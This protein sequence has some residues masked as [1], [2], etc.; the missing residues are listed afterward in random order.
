MKSLSFRHYISVA[1]ACAVAKCF[2]C[3][4]SS[5]AWPWSATWSAAPSISWPT[6]GSGRR[7]VHACLTTGMRDVRLHWVARFVDT[8][9]QCLLR[10][11]TQNCFTFPSISVVSGADMRLHDWRGKQH[12]DPKVLEW[13]LGAVPDKSWATAWRR[14]HGWRAVRLYLITCIAFDCFESHWCY[15]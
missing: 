6:G 11:S 7:H 2:G 15:F 13:N 5:E 4:C 3:S 9:F 14:W 8:Y 12:D 10:L 1:I